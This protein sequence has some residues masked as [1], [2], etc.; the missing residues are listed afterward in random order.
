MKFIYCGYYMFRE[1]VMWA[2]EEKTKKDTINQQ[3]LLL[4][5][6]VLMHIIKKNKIRIISPY[7]ITY[8][9]PFNIH[10]AE[11]FGI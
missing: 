3:T 10:T 8:Y 5:S 6:F 4:Y 1:R 11:W 2:L 9:M 7:Y